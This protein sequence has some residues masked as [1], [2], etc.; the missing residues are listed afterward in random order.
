[1]N[2]IPPIDKDT[3]MKQY[4]LMVD[5][6]KFYFEILL[7]FLVF[8]YAVTGAIVS[9]YLS[10]PNVG[11]I[12]FA[13]AFPIFMSIVFG[14]FAFFASCRIQSIIDEIIRVTTALDL[15]AYPDATFLKHM[16]TVTW[17]LLAAIAIGL[18]IVSCIRPV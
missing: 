1:M 17:L 10:Q 3:L 9:F 15:R 5:I 14:A 11:F 13:L 2:T 16:L 6:Y 18:S 7:K 12:R 4:Q 8:H